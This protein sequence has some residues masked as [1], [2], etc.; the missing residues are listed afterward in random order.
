MSRART[1]FDHSATTPVDPRVLE[2]MIPYFSVDFGNPSS[3]HRY[4]QKAEAALSTAR[5]TIAEALGCDTREIIFT[6]HGTESDN[7]ALRG[8]A[9]AARE[10][11]GADHILISPTE[12]EAVHKTAYELQREHGFELEMLPVDR[13]GRVAPQDLESRL[14]PTTAVVSVM[15]A[16]NEVGTINP[17]LELA[18]IT[19]RYAIPFHTDAVQAATYLDMD[20]N[21]LSVDLLSLS[22]HKFYGPKGIG[23][24][25]VRNGTPISPVL[26]GGE[27][28]FGLRPGTENIPLAVGTAHALSLAKTERQSEAPRLTALRDRLIEGV[29]TGVPGS[30]LTGHATERLPNHASFL[31]EAVNGNQLLAALD[32]EGF[33]C[34]SGSAC[35]TGDPKPSR[36]LEALGIHGSLALSSLRLTIGRST[37]SDQVGRFLD[38]LPAV[39]DRLRTVPETV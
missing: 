2:K 37:D 4:G 20:L 30:S 6:A 9:A 23:V 15:Y 19:Q 11:R 24:L 33:A 7:I 10:T 22:A 25:F 8:A 35:K 21:R 17:I 27:Q 32:L 28:E 13:Y 5:V 29:L 39:I 26:T 18:S 14:R 1:Y 34:S 31:F 38:R 36:V 16:N 12:H 3:V